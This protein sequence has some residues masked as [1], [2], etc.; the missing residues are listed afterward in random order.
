MKLIYYPFKPF[1]IST[2][3]PTI[4]ETGNHEVY[5]KLLTNFNDMADDLNFGNESLE[6]VATTKAVKWFG[7]ASINTD[8]NKLFLP[9]LYKQIKLNLT[10]EQNQM[11]IDQSRSLKNY[12]LEATYSLDLPLDVGEQ[13]MMEKVLKLCDI[14]FEASLTT[15][16]YGIM[17][18]ILKTA[19]ELNETRI[20]GFMNI[21]DYLTLNELQEIFKLIRTLD[22]PVLIIKFSE[23]QRSVEFNN[24]RYYYIDQD[25]VDWRYD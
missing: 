11:I 12:V 21:S 1:Q 10:S 4:I 3:T 13:I 9:Q 19:K 18:T 7:D 6:L 24:C 15:D 23:I 22:L 20:L 5:R 17:E 14:H 16:C 25:Y 8:L 2:G